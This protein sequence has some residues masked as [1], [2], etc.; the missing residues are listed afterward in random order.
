MSYQSLGYRRVKNPRIW[1]LHDLHAL[2]E[3]ISGSRVAQAVDEGA[4]PDADPAG[5]DEDASGQLREGESELVRSP[6]DGIFYARPEPGAPPFVDVGDCITPGQ[7]IGLVE[8]MKTF[9]PIRWR[10]DGEKTAVVARIEV[11]D[12][13]ELRSGQVLLA[14]I[15]NE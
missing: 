13:Q 14:L 12:Q 5:A 4:S 15:D 8:V 10:S 7:V 1:S 2:T 3:G 11:K 9:N 6:I